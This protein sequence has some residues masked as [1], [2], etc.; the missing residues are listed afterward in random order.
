MRL[1]EEVVK[2]DVTEAVRLWYTAMSGSASSSDGNI[3]MDNIFTGATTAARQAQK[4]LP[5]EL[6]SL[7]QGTY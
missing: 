2:S 5:E 1:S 7:M 6:R 3:D 4:Q